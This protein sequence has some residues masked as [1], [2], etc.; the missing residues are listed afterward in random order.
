MFVLVVRRRG[1]RGGLGLCGRISW[2]LRDWVGF[3]N[4]VVNEDEIL[5]DIDS[6]LLFA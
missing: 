2:S 3:A 4:W 6:N 1:V 5:S